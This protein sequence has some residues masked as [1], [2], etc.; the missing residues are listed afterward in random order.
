MSVLRH[1]TLVAFS[2]FTVCSCSNQADPLKSFQT[3]ASQCVSALA[4]PR[5]PKIYSSPTSGKWNKLVFG[6]NEVKFDVRKSDS[7]VSPYTGWISITYEDAVLQRDT[8]QEAEATVV[9]NSTVSVLGTLQRYH[10]AYAYQDS[11]W[12][13]QK[14][15]SSM[16]VT[17]LRDMPTET[18]SIDVPQLSKTF[19]EASMCAAAKGAALYLPKQEQ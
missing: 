4:S 12:Q 17:S 8:R 16:K 5:A 15:D 19:P 7:L 3:I 6:P 9:S 1:S 2:A 18:V 10:I 11:K 13:L 14:I